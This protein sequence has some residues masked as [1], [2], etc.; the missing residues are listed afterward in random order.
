MGWENDEM[1]ETKIWISSWC[2][3]LEIRKMRMLLVHLCFSP[4][5]TVIHTSDLGSQPLLLNFCHSLTHSTSQICSP[6]HSTDLFSI[7]GKNVT[8]S[9]RSV[10]QFNFQL[11]ISLDFLYMLW[12]S[13]FLP[14][15]LLPDIRSIGSSAY[16]SNSGEVWNVLLT[17]KFSCLFFIYI[18]LIFLSLTSADTDLLGKLKPLVRIL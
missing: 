5:P 10:S 17:F 14:P 7:L 1:Q 6:S 12:I 15:F 13:Y 3:T 8:P 2:G 11:H 18:W 9:L 16:F 4:R